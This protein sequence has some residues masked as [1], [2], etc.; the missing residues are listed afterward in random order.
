MIENAGDRAW[1]GSAR[2]VDVEEGTWRAI[3]V[4]VMPLRNCVF[5]RAYRVIFRDFAERLFEWTASRVA[6]DRQ[7]FS[8]GRFEIRRLKFG[9]D[10][11]R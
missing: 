7:N 5:L 3:T 1:N 8:T 4:P 11:L 9:F 10:R 2:R 6:A